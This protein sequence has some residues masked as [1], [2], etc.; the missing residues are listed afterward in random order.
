M[1]MVVGI[2]RL[3]WLE[4]D[5]EFEQ[6]F[7][8]GHSETSFFKAHRAAFGH[9]NDFLLI[10][11]EAEQGRSVWDSAY[12][13]AFDGLTQG[14]KA[15]PHVRGITSPTTVVLPIGDP[16]LGGVFKRQ[17]IRWQ[18]V[19]TYASDSIGI[20]SRPHVLGH[21][22]SANH[23]SAALLLEHDLG[24]SKEGCDTLA[25]AVQ[26]LLDSCPYPSH[27]S[28][29]ATSQL[30]IIEILG[31]EIFKFS[32]LGLLLIASL[33]WLAFRTWWGVA[34]P[35]AVVLMS[36]VGTLAAIETSGYG[37]D[38]MTVVLP[39]ILFV[40]GISDAV[41]ISTRYL[42]ELRSGRPAFQALRTTF[43][44]V[45][46]ATFTT[47]LTTAIGFL[48]L[49]TSPIAPIRRFGMFSA[50]GVLLAYV[51][52]FTVLPSILLLTGPR[53]EKRKRSQALWHRGLDA[54]FRWSL[55]HRRVLPW[56][57]LALTLM[58]AVG[59]AGLRADQKLLQDLRERDP[60]QLDFRFFEAEF[61]GVRPFELAYLM[62][63]EDWKSNAKIWNAMERIEGH[64]D[65]ELGV[66]GVVSPVS[67]IKLAHRLS[68]RDQP[69]AYRL[70]P[71]SQLPRMVRRVDDSPAMM[72]RAAGR[73]ADRGS[74]EMKV[75]GD[76][77]HAF[78]DSLLAA[79]F[80]RAP[81]E[82]R[83]TGTAH[84]IDVANRELARDMIIGLLIAFL[85]V[86]LIAG[87]MFRSATLVAIALWVNILPLLSAAALMRVLGIDLNLGTS[88][89]FTIAFGIAVDDT[90]HMLSHFRLLLR[91]GHGPAFAVR[92][93]L[94]RAGKAIIITS[95]IL[96]AGFM[97]LTTSQLIGPAHIGWL[98]AWVLLVAVLV[99]LTLLPILLLWWGRKVV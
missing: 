54:W 68:N 9:D 72:A 36:I 64:M 87:L 88:V 85:V 61:A 69:A 79:D 80:I 2:W 93:A 16:A 20:E 25:K 53:P 70:P 1:A 97:T 81:F 37:I 14:L 33:L 29:R 89:L 39:T 67:R 13:G 10:A 17:L 83:I 49:W 11:L 27:I 56:V 77:L 42:D 44:D 66:R 19:E 5:Y 59:A 74:Q 21:L 95:A 3:S 96:V 30:H 15:A 32:I 57:G 35:M 65:R 43:Q 98:V 91:R 22:I 71:A 7:P 26:K 58:A 41:H 18:Q 4:F 12:W 51:L 78:T 90:L 84:L 40:V 48:S 94:H 8:T 23:R 62:S 47:S 76:N 46:L 6:L 38:M 34:V 82:I 52:A 55:K 24:L 60:V 99:D 31:D 86:A 73:V 28:G 92:R 63:D 75:L 50:L 45:G